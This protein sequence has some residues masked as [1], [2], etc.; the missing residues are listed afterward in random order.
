MQIMSLFLF[1][2]LNL[3][4]VAF[5]LSHQHLYKRFIG[6][7][8]ITLFCDTYFAWRPLITQTNKSFL[9]SFVHFSSLLHPISF[10]S[11]P[12][13]LYSD[14]LLSFCNLHSLPGFLLFFLHRLQFASSEMWIS[15]ACLALFV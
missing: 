13:P 11:V 14:S 10:V 12:F 5:R 2:F 9:L 15:E 4:V 6:D 1:Q 8:S 7:H 3:F